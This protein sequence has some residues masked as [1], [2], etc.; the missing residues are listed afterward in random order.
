M[1][2]YTVWSNIRSREEHLVTGEVIFQVNDPENCGKTLVS[3]WVETGLHSGLHLVEAA[4]ME[5][6]EPDGSFGTAPRLIFGNSGAFDGGFGTLRLPRAKVSCALQTEGAK[7]KIAVKLKER[8]GEL[9]LKVVFFVVPS[10]SAAASFAGSPAVI[11]AEPEKE[12]PEEEK[13]ALEP[14]QKAAP[15]T[16]EEPSKEEGPFFIENPPQYL[17]VGWKY[18]L[19][20]NVPPEK[21]GRILWEVLSEGGGSIDGYGCYTAPERP[22]A[23]EVVAT[24]EKSGRLASCF[25]IVKA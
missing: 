15:M 5:E 19:R 1:D 11:A 4:L 10:L 24:E 12:P 22:G 6:V 18:T 17:H 8:P 16:A 21:T 20:T 13:P 23:Y 3:D 2:A 7:V 25:M 14:E 9:T